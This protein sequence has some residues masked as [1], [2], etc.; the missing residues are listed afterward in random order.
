ME[1]L[2]RKVAISHCSCDYLVNIKVGLRAAAKTSLYFLEF[3]HNRQHF[4]VN[5]C[6]NIIW[7]R[8]FNLISAENDREI[9]ATGAEEGQPKE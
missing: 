4:A 7:R 8:V 2:P 9:D 1:E 5:S 6:L 3:L